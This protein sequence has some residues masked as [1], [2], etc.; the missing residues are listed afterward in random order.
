MPQGSALGPIIFLVFINEMSEVVE[1]TCRLL[2]DNSIIYTTINDD[3]DSAI[4]QADLDWLHT[5]KLEWGM[6]FNSSKCDSIHITRRSQPA[7]KTYLFKGVTLG[8]V[9]SAPYLV[10]Y[11]HKSLS[12]E[13]RS[14]KV[15]GKLNPRILKANLKEASQ[16][17]KSMAY[18]TLVRPHLESCSTVWSLYHAYQ[19]LDLEMVQSRAVHFA[20]HLYRHQSVTATLTELIRSPNTWYAS[21]LM[22]FR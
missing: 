5:W 19:I 14:K 6:S 4:L 13:N 22:N 17:N 11:I 21:H 3:K 7:N 12:W 16:F 15:T 1:S 8:N 10:V 20:M 18:H 2:A 9:T